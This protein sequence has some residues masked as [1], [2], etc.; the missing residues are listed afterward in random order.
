M[1]PSRG[2]QSHSVGDR[3][4]AFTLDRESEEA[5]EAWLINMNKYFLV[6]E[7]DHQLNARLAIFQL[8]AKATLWWEE[9]KMV[10]GVTEQT[11]TWE[12]FQ[13]YFK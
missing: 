2:K 9:V 13:K 4:Q 6:Y 8:Q 7:Y 12:N 3:T 11:I 10:K 5:A 1:A